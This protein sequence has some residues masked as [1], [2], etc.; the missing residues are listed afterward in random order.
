VTTAPRVTLRDVAE[1]AG[2]SRTT[3]SFVM[4]GRRDMRISADAEE[5]VRR[6]AREL[7]YRPNLMA[8]SLRTNN[9]QTI[10]LIS[11]VIATEAFAGEVVRGTLATA[12]LRNHLML[13]GETE[14]DT[15]VEQRLVQ[16]MLDR[17]VRGFLYGAMSTRRATVP[18]ILRGHSVVLLNCV[19]RG[20]AYPMVVPDER[21]AGRTAA[22]A[23]LA[24]GHR[25]GIWLVGEA[26]AHVIAAAERLDG[27]RRALDAAGTE[28]AGVIDCLWWPGAARE[29][30]AAFLRDGGGPSAF[31][32]M[33]DRVAL[34]IYQAVA[35]AG[36]GVPDD[37]SVVSFDDSDLAVW[38]RPALSSV[39]LPHREMAT[40]AIRLLLDDS[41]ESPRAVRVP[42]P[43]RVR[44][45]IGP[46]R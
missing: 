20:R 9:S 32:A 6:A 40:E 35:G 14:G 30:V 3:A 25:D 31:I 10:G 39:A 46:P 36:L 18:A 24:A 33:N 15:E 45:S 44:E 13:I 43:L 34:G 5:R 4:T 27:V 22:S 26:P 12:V 7:D 17:G 42:M 21:E 19:T 11:D 8:R 37:V 41:E 1:R 16:D 29:A 28:P 2:V 23:L 38:L